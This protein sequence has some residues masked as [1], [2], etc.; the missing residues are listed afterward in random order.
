MSFGSHI[1]RKRAAEAAV[2]IAICAVIFIGEAYAYLPDDYGYGS[3]ASDAGDYAEYTVTVN[4]SHEYAASLI[5]CG[6]YVPVSS[7]Y[8]FLEEGRTSQYSDGSDLFLSRMDEPGFYLEQ[9]ETALRVCG[10]DDT[11]YMDMD[12]LAEAL[13]SDIYEG[14]A[15]GK[16]LVMVYGA[17]PITVYDGSSGG[18]ALE[19]MEAGGTVY[20]VGPAPGDYV[21]ARDGYE[22]AG[23][24]AFFT[25]T[26]EYLA[27]DDPA[28]TEGPFRKELQLKGDLLMNAPDMSGT[29]ME[30]LTA[31]YTSGNRGT[32]TFVREGSGQI[33]IAA[34]GVSLFQAEDIAS[35]ASAGLCWCSVLLDTCSGT[36]HGS[37]S[38]TLD[39]NGASGTLCVYV[40]VG[41]AYQIYA[42]RHQI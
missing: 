31:G 8:L 26:A 41:D 21:M 13:Q 40:T 15:A 32:L 28:D 10:I 34:G 3:S 19:W 1:G 30:S 25:G 27:E 38:G 33:C 24:R 37:D 6:D 12:G 23:G 4:G 18:T 17:F 42:C 16:G 7:V 22:Y 20:W 2:V 29:G 9:T 39:K 36:A 11:V 5:S 35:A 14:T